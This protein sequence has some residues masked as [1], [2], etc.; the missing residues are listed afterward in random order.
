MFKNSNYIKSYS[1]ECVRGLYSEDLPFILQLLQYFV[2]QNTAH[3]TNQMDKTAVFQ[4]FHKT[5]LRKLLTIKGR[6]K[7]GETYRIDQQVSQ[8]T[9]G[10]L[11]NRPQLCVAMSKF[12]N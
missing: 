8:Q 4:V 7:G 3:V 6:T 5:K 1:E 10:F 2:V 11:A 9:T 12:R